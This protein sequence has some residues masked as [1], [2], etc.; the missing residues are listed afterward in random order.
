MGNCLGEVEMSL[1]L[2]GSG[3]VYGNEPVSSIAATGNIMID[4]LM[5]IKPWIRSLHF[6][7]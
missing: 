2:S 4:N 6:I 1:R 7:T 3:F 5:N